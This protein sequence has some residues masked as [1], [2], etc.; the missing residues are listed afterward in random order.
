M[1]C[2][3]SCALQDCCANRTWDAGLGEGGVDCGGPC[4]LACQPAGRHDRWTQTNGPWL[5]YVRRIRFDPEDLD[6]LIISSNTG[7][8]VVKSTDG[9]QTWHEISGSGQY[10]ISP[11]NVFGLAMDPDSKDVM[12]AGTA[13]GRLYV[14][15][16]GGDTWELLWQYTEVDDALWSVEVDPS[17][18]E[19]LFVGMG[20]YT[21]TEGRIYRSEDRGETWQKVLDL[22][23]SSD[24]DAGFISHIAFDPIDSTTMYAT[25]GI[26][27]YCGGG[28]PGDPDA[29]SYGIWKS[30]DGGTTWF[31]VTNG[32]EDMTVS[33]MVI[34]PPTPRPYTRAWAAWTTTS[35]CRATSS[36]RSTAVRA[37]SGSTC[38]R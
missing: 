31:T 13:N 28:D 20:D 3:G 36:N 15:E 11:M 37:G 8:G 29:V 30:I 24:L 27:D 16:D 6:T 14:T 26:G 21:S 33:H 17:D 7:S 19:R 25:T 35:T 22:D 18:S 12:Y 38:R 2:G 9:G 4:A 34:D 32:L 23:P 1:D 5:E 10:A